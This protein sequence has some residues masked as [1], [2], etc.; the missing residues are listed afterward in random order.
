[1]LLR[2]KDGH[3]EQSQIDHWELVEAALRG[4]VERASTT[5]TNHIAAAAQ[6]ILT[7]MDSDADAS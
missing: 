2:F 3:F 6:K 1:M 4:D 5:L 7:L